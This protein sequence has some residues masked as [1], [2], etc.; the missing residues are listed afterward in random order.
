M[1]KRRNI[2]QYT[3]D[4]KFVATHATISDA[5][6]AVGLSKQALSY[7]MQGKGKTA[8]GY[9]WR[10]YKVPQLNMEE[11]FPKKKEG[12]SRPCLSRGRHGRPVAQYTKDG[13]LVKVHPSIV[14]AGKETWLEP[15]CICNCLRGRI[16]TA[17]GFVWEYCLDA[18][19]ET[20]EVTA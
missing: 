15:S 16:K 12:D 13:K 14:S 7:L 2:Y 8:G 11:I 6:K 18:E 3:L 10:Y 20:V 9:L 4:G 17:G 19:L 5:A 1:G